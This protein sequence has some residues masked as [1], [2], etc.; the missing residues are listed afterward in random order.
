MTNV[1]DALK[2]WD[3]LF[4]EK[5]NN[6]SLPAW[7]DSVFPDQLHAMAVS[8]LALPTQTLYMKMVKGGPLVK[9]IVDQMR[10][11][12]VNNSNR[13]IYVYSGH[14]STL[15]SVARLLNL[16]NQTNGVPAFGATLTFELHCTTSD[17][18][19]NQLEIRVS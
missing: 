18:I 12:Q 13:S 17:A 11:K 8:A 15:L 5:G 9:K 3:I 16:N 14:D 6:M 7:T 4:I 19:C 10:E 1:K 2:L